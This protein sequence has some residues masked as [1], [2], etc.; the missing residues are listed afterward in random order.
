MRVAR[1]AYRSEVGVG[2]ID[3]DWLAD[4][5]CPLSRSPLVRSGD[6]LYTT[7]RA[8]RRKY[9]IREGIPVLLIDA[10]VEVTN[11]EFERAVGARCDDERRPG[12][13]R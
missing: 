1:V 5:R 13:N 11:E 9:P 7:D 8:T 6:W 4:L 3:E 12:G 2:A 10:G